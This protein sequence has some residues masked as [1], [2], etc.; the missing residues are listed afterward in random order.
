MLFNLQV[1]G[2]FPAT[3][4]LNV[5]SL[6]HNQS[7]FFSL[8]PP[9]TFVWGAECCLT[10]FQV[11]F[12][13]IHLNDPWYLIV[14]KFQS[15]YFLLTSNNSTSIMLRIYFT[16]NSVPQPPSQ[17]LGDP[18]KFFLGTRSLTHAI[19]NQ[20]LSIKYLK[21]FFILF[22]QFQFSLASST[23]IS[24]LNYWSSILIHLPAFSFISPIHLALICQSNYICM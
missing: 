24:Y 15:T 20:D 6:S 3:F 12:G 23:P 18:P 17:K 22:S 14:N 8:L 4:L 21:H 10:F 2:E 7:G 5:F 11:S 1:F 9:C 16:G 19:S 13:W